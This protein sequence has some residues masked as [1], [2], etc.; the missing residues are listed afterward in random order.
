MKKSGE[1]DVSPLFAFCLEMHPV[2]V[3]LA[4]LLQV[5]ESGHAGVLSHIVLVVT[6]SISFAS[7]VCESSLIPL[8]LLS[9]SN[10]LRWALM[11]TPELDDVIK[12]GRPMGD[13]LESLCLLITSG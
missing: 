4:I 9:P 7:A 10:P 11:G 1:T 8:F 13:P 5:E 2:G 6:S 3:Y 12:A